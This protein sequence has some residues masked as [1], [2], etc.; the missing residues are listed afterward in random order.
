[1][2]RKAPAPVGGIVEGLLDRLGIAEKVERATVL[3]EWGDIVGP[4][5]A[6]KAT[7]VGFSDG[8]LFVEVLSASWRMELNMMRRD[9]LQRLNAGKKRG[10]IE[11]IVF[12]QADGTPDDGGRRR[13]K[14]RN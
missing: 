11:R 8:T 7:P 13:A 2:K 6:D 3:N 4:A 14:E 12:V 9:L 10:R 5:I 1:M